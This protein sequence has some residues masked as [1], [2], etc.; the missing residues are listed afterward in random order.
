MLFWWTRR[1]SGS[2]R[3][4]I[5]RLQGEADVCGARRVPVAKCLA[6]QYPAYYCI[7]PKMTDRGP[8]RLHFQVNTFSVAALPEHKKRPQKTSSVFRRSMLLEQFLFVFIRDMQV[9]VARKRTACYA[10]LKPWCSIP[11]SLHLYR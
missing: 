10:S 6:K 11:I 5:R 3:P 1:S 7:R 8:R 9:R 4:G 2:V